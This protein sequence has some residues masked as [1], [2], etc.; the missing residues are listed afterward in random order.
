MKD[1]KHLTQISAISNSNWNRLFAFIPE[2]EEANDFG[3]WSESEQSANGVI[4]MPHYLPSIVVSDFVRNAYAIGIILDFDWINWKE[5]QELL[6]NNKTD[7]D[8]LDKVTLCML[9]TMIIRADRFSEGYLLR[10]F[11]DGLIVMLLQCLE[12]KYIK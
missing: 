8:L 7:F 5:G 10:C 12:Q 3:K 9:L 11:E 6:R 1:D 2:I 4:I